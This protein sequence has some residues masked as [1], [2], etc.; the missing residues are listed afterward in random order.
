MLQR[1]PMTLAQ[2]KERNISKKSLTEIR[3]SYIL[4]NEQN[5]LLKKYTKHYEFNTGIIQRW[6]LYLWIMKIVKHFILTGYH[7]TLQ[8]K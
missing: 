1:L 4:C 7:S 5:K 8:I 3:K 6:I 2:L